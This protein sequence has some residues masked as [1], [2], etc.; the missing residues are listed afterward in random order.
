MAS[1]ISTDEKHRNTLAVLQEALDYLR[2]MPPVPVTVEMCGKLQRHLEHPTNRLVA[3]QQDTWAG[4]SYQPSGLCYLVARMKGGLLEVRIPQDDGKFQKHIEK[5]ALE[6]LRTGVLIQLKNRG[7][8]PF[9]AD[10]SRL[11]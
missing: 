1:S 10:D 9:D 4:E 2:R 7:F 8:D 11:P 5:V 3:E 6:Q